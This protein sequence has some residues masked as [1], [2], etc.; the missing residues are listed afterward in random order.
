[1]S[2]SSLL[3]TNDVCYIS[4]DELRSHVTSSTIVK[5]LK[6]SMYHYS[7]KWVHIPEAEALWLANWSDGLNKQ[8]EIIFIW[9]PI[10]CHLKGLDR[11]Y[12]FICVYYFAWIRICYLPYIQPFHRH[13]ALSIRTNES[14][15]VFSVYFAVRLLLFA[16]ESAIVWIPCRHKKISILFISFLW[17]KFSTVMPNK[18]VNISVKLPLGYS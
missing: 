8:T 4:Y 3:R 1:M 11:I 5:M 16:F 2:P 9:R 17:G 12:L 14:D 15:M 10:K 18:N 13:S 6:I 7:I